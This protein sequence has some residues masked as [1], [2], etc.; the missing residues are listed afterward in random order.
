MERVYAGQAFL[1]FDPEI[2]LP[3]TYEWNVALQQSLGTMQTIS[4]SYVGAAG[5]DL[6][7]REFVAGNSPNSL[8]SGIDVTTNTATSEYHALQIQLQRRLSRGIQG[9]ASYSWWHSIDITSN[10]FDDQ[11]PST[12]VLPE[13]NRA[14]SDFDARHTFNAAFVYEMPRLGDGVLGSIFHGWSVDGIFTARTA[15]P[16]NVTV[17]RSFG[18]DRIAVNPDLVSGVPLY[19]S[20]STVAG[21]KRTNPAAFVA[22]LDQRQG[23]LGRNALRGFP[24]YE[25]DLSVG[26]VFNVTQAIKLQL[27]AD[28]FNLLNHPNFADPSGSLGIFRPPLSPNS[29]FGV[30]TAML[31]NTPVDGATTGLTPLFHTGGPRSLQISLR[32]DF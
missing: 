1:V 11:I 31:A 26:R 19:L 28:A 4:V 3:R 29:L 20:D 10:D 5:R 23:N 15:M 17:I 9:L 12:H 30:S 13:A 16:V 21:G 2:V 27:R 7:R 24:V 14:S 18:P 6:L 25:L 32:L 8:S 22:P